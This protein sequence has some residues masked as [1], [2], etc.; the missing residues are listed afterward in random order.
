MD[1][2]VALQTLTGREDAEFRPHQREAVEALVAHQRVLVVQ[3]T[4]WGKSAVY[5]LATHLLREQGLGPT[6]LIS[7]L[8]A[9][10]RNQI[11]AA[12]RLGLR[13][14]TVNSSSKTTVDELSDALNTDSL[15]LILVSPERLANP[16]FAAKVMPMLEERPGMMVID[17]VHCISDWGHDFRPDY[18]RIGQMLD[19]FGQGRVPILGCTATA[20]LRVVDDVAEQ[21]GA[22]LTTFR[23]ALGRSGL[24]LGVVDLPAQP[25]RLVWLAERL[26]AMPG[27]G[28][29]YCL[30]IR[31]TLAVSDFLQS[32][33]F[34]VAA[35][36][37]AT[38]S[39]EREQLERRLQANQL[40]A[41]VATSALGMG[42]DKPDLGFVI[43]FQMPGSP[44]AYY[45]QVGRA[46]RAL[47]ES[48]AILLVGQEDLRIQNHFI[49]RAFPDPEKVDEVL[50]VLDGTRGPIGMRDIAAEVNVKWG[51]IESI[52]K[53]LDVE[54]TVRR[55]KGQSYERTEQRWV[56]P[57]ERVDN[58]TQARRFE[59]QLMRDYAET[60]GCRMQ[61]LTALLDDPAEDPCGIC[62]NCRRADRVA[63]GASAL[64]SL[65]DSGVFAPFEPDSVVLQRAGDFLRNRPIVL[66]PKKQGIPTEE[67]SEVGHAL[68]VWGDDGW[69]RAIERGKYAERH[70]GDDLV[71]ALIDL[72][73]TWAPATSIEWVTAVPSHRSG[74]LVPDLAR[75]LAARLGIPF[76]AAV[77]RIDERPPQE[78]QANSAHQR[79]NVEG[80]FDASGP[81]P[82]G[83][84]LLVDDL[85]DSG[86]TLTEVGRVLRRAGSGPVLPL[87]L[88]TTPI[89]S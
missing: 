24:A 60:S 55:V 38:D 66:A 41:L 3:R 44:I 49:D 19:E 40:K 59:Q 17:E 64:D 1:L 80:A 21:L 43:H 52:L 5:F 75:R 68:A 88:A 30:T 10:M 31:D 84:V 85:I 2:D 69:G 37:G 23:G 35:Y 50:A 12:T 11:E 74:D 81:V 27:S 70:F 46:G 77:V 15:D 58:V 51:D 33:G 53:Q 48:V 62:D 42:Y 25:E 65:A 56:Y 61:F 36:S 18:R 71:G 20:N 8:L 28:I 22:E 72:V 54:G 57:T 67:R 6:L 83:P 87:T 76:E 73:A 9:L 39:D 82:S 47:T 13:C 89:R 26:D 45:Q 14:M 86:W 29:V 79:S 34:D 16:E 32:R 63:S 7:P 4:G 78:V